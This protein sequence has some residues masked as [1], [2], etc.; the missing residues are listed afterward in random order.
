[1]LVQS[2]QSRFASAQSRATTLLA[3][4]GV[5]AGLGITLAVGMEDRV[6]PWTVDLWGATVSLALAML[7]LFGAVSVAFLIMTGAL[8]LGA[9]QPQI[10]ANSN[11]ESLTATIGDQFPA[12]L[13]DSTVD[14]AETIL[15]LLADQLEVVQASNA[16]TE[17]ALGRSAIC[18]GI[19]IAAGV[20]LSSLTLAVS[21]PPD[22][23]KSPP[24]ADRPEL[25]GS[26][27]GRP[28]G[29]PNP[30]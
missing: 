2:E 18:L 26:L 13:E 24:G 1:M 3:I 11:P 12:M 5:I 4:T 8:A 14:S 9:M 15:G 6:F 7:A 19:S 16:E 27:S 22:P 28:G 25:A 29:Y 23:T 20:V 10:G 21:S 17:R 30:R